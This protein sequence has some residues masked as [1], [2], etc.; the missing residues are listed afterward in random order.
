VTDKAALGQ[1][2]IVVVVVAVVVCPPPRPNTLV[3][4]CHCQSSM[5]VHIHS[6][7]IQ[8]IENATMAG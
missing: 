4:P 8:G 7:I 2:V 3:F 1:V 5:M 6:P